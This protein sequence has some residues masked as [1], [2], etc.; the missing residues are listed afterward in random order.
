MIRNPKALGLA[1]FAVF[2]MSAVAAQAASAANGILTSDGPVTLT[3]TETGTSANRMSFFGVF[4][5]CPGSV[6][7]GHKYNVTPHE[8]ITGSSETITLNPH[9]KQTTAG[10]APN[11]IG[12]AGSST[13]IDF[14]S[15][16]DYVAHVGETTGGVAG[17][18]GVTFDVNCANPSTESITVTTWL[19]EARHTANPT[20][21]DCVLH[22]PDNA[23][24]HGLAGAHL[25]DTGNGTVDLTGTIS[26]ITATQTRNSLLCPSGTH[27]ETASFSLDITITGH[28]EAGVTTG[29][30]LSHN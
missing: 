27:T 2:A 18:Y 19:S 8:F 26:G 25:T 5:E 24:N 20:A 17:T 14:P 4:F 15:G 6:Y 12:T 21:P 16:C 23:H 3:G 10:G 9:Y 22:I 28:N 30:S 1:L 7:T 29:I 11:C 13:T